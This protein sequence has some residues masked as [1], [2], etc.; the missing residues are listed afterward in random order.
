MVSIV[1][2]V[3]ITYIVRI[4]SIVSGAHAGP[5]GWADREAPQVGGAD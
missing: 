4:E 5:R 1:R 2:I 3:F